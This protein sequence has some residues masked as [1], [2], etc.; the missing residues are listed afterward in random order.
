MI[1]QS[2]IDLNGSYQVLKDGSK[3]SDLFDGFVKIDAFLHV[4]AN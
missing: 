2:T 3:I 1:G 4:A